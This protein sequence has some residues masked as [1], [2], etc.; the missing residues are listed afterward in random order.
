MVAKKKPQTSYAQVPQETKD[1][2]NQRRRELDS[3]LTEVVRAKRNEWCRLAYAKK[4]NI[5]AEI[6]ESKKARLN[7]SCTE[8]RLGE[9]NSHGKVIQSV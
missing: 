5:Y 2:R 4:A 1:K 7:N 8:L 9:E 3:N 6:L